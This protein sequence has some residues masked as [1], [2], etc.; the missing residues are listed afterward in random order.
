MHEHIGV[1]GGHVLELVG[2]ASKRE[3][4]ELSYAARE[5]LGELRLGI[6]AGADRGAA[7]GDGIKFT[8]RHGK[9]HGGGLHLS[10]IAGKF[11]AQG[12]R[13]GIHGVGAADFDDLG[14]FFRLLGERGVQPHERRQ[15]MAV[16]FDCRGDMHGARDR[17]VGRLAHID[18]I[19]GMH[20]LFRAEF[21]AER[22]IGGVRDHLVDVHIALGAGAGLPHQQRK[23]L[24][25]LAVGDVLRHRDDR[26]GAPG[27]EAA[28]I[29]VD[30]GGGALDQAE[31]AHDFDRHALAADAE[32]MQRAL[33]LR[34]PQ[35]VGGDSERPEGVAFD[36]SLLAGFGGLSLGCSFGHR[37]AVIS[38][39]GSGRGG[40]LRRRLQAC[41][42]PVRPAPP[43]SDRPAPARPWRAGAAC[44][45]S[46]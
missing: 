28:E 24:I 9:A 29:A 46:S 33:G 15:Q 1:V 8:L 43:L 13:R 22:Q 38:S 40:P 37:A 45:A 27:V 23:M 32:I 25:Q 26:L 35:S 16:D 12:E 44:R 41:R 34:A 14:E 17:V 31:R 3:F 7:L 19:V 21:A 30:L 2:R 4:G 36:A 6:Q 20:Q 11:L 5:C 10:G 18:V 39:C 42:A